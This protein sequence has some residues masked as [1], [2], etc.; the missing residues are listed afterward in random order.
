MANYGEISTEKCMAFCFKCK[1]ARH[2]NL[3]M[4]DGEQGGGDAEYRT[5]ECPQRQQGGDPRLSTHTGDDC[6][7]PSSSQTQT[8]ITAA[9]M[10]M[11]FAWKG[12]KSPDMPCLENTSPTAC[13]SAARMPK[14]TQ[15][16]L[17]FRQADS[18]TLRWTQPT[19]SRPA[20]GQC[21]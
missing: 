10:R 21:P 15:S 6:A 11:A 19:Q 7:L 9:S 8:K 13:P 5:D 16:A 2:T 1:G 12:E 4:L 17:Y 14:I 20:S 18:V 3:G